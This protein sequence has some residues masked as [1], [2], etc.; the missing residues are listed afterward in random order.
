MI[1]KIIGEF[2]T[3]LI[4]EIV[5]LRAQNIFCN[6]NQDWEF[7]SDWKDKFRLIH[8]LTVVECKTLS[9]AELTNNQWVRSLSSAALNE[10][11]VW[12]QP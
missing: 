2:E 5:N 10:F 9:A 4:D 11:A 1:L 7:G 3:G 8:F 6:F 12:V